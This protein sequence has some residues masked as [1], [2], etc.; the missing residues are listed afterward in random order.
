VVKAA[1]AESHPAS[2]GRDEKSPSRFGIRLPVLA[3]GFLLSILNGTVSHAAP[4][5]FVPG[6]ILVKPKAHVSDAD[7][8]A[9]TKAHGASEKSRLSELNVRV[10]S[11]PE[12]RAE[13]VLNALSHNPN[14]EFAE[15]DFIAQSTFVP[16]DPYVQNGSAWHLNKI[17]APQAWDLATGR[18]TVI[19][20][21]L[22]SGVKQD[23]ADLAARMLTG[24]NF[25]SNNSNT[26]DD[27]G[28]G[29][30]VAGAAAALGNNGIGVAGVGYGCSIL[31]VKVLDASGYGAYSTIAAGINYS[32][33]QG[34][35]VISI[36]IAGGSSSSTLQNAVNYA[37][38]KNC[39]I[40]AAAGNNGSPTAMYPAACANVM[41]ISATE[42]DDTKASFSNYGNHIAV[43]APG[44]VIWTTQNDNTY[45][46][47]GWWGTSL[48]TPVVAGLAG[49]VASANATLSNAQIVSLI[50]N[51]AD[52]LGPNG[53]DSS[54][55]WGR[56]NARRA[57]AAAMGGT[58]TVP[59]ST[60]IA[61]PGSGNSLSGVVSV[62]V[63]SS[64]NIAVTRVECYA[65]NIPLG[66]NS[67]PSVQFPWSTFANSNGTYQLQSRAYDAAGNAGASVAV[68]VVVSNTRPSITSQPASQ[69]VSAG[70]PVTFSVTA[71]GTS[72]L[73][74]QWKFNNTAIAGATASSYTKNSAQAL[75]T[76]SYTVVVTNALGSVT[77]LPAL[78]TVN[79]VPVPQ[80]RPLSVSGGTVTISWTAQ[81][82][83]SYR[84]QYA[85]TPTGPWSTLG[86]D[87]VANG[88]LASKLDSPAGATQ[89]YYRVI[90]L[91]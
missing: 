32:A 31:P 25:V 1:T 22:D 9:L 26:A 77:S 21:I 85:P 2:Q 87:V 36:S 78:L 38:G 71:A 27:S 41:G 80:L 51:N 14:I 58:D 81:S 49:L 37:W 70:S 66:T 67:N 34:A 13:V 8:V 79:P 6:Q 76:G 83:R 12:S 10:L 3:F 30:A 54:F 19:I 56:I 46:Y 42:A 86:T 64:D 39:I 52:D 7:F 29:T 62:Q 55:G 57:V 84:V 50:K 69:I 11:V 89:R 72:P 88:T 35:R 33:N 43:A 44:N 68:T 47:G 17:Q 73:G 48:A 75:D 91:P 15:R 61:S 59:P 90:L 28:H 24:F 53:F 60:T 16:N 45:P 18:S 5:A 4:S 63:N 65:N 82:G 74:Y 23:H 20:A 40:V